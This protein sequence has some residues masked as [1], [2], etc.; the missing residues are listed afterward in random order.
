MG[1][2]W[3]GAMGASSQRIS[4]MSLHFAEKAAARAAQCG[5]V[6][7]EVAV[8]LHGGAA[9]GGVDDDG[10]DV[11]GFEERD[12]ALRA[13]AAACSSRPEWTMRAPQQGWLCGSDDF[14]AF[15]GEDA[16]GGGVDVREEDV[17]HAA[18]EHADA[19]ARCGGWVRLR[20]SGHAAVRTGWRDTA[21]GGL[22]SRRG[23]SGASLSRPEA[24]TRLCRPE[25]W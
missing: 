13:M 16:R 19:A 25:R 24:R 15:G 11:G 10:V 17:L 4:V 8:L 18:G 14:A 1:S 9:A 5:V 12:D 6:A 3:R 22:P 7:E 21:G 23:A 2:G 20:V